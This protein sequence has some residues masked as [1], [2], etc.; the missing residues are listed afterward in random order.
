[1][2]A[3]HRHNGGMGARRQRGAVLYIAL[4]ILILLALIGIAGMQVSG[5][6]ERMSANYL[7]VNSAFQNAEANARGIERIIQTTADGGGVYAV[8]SN[9]CASGVS[10][11]LADNASAKTAHY[12]RRIDQCAA[13]SGSAMNLGGTTEQSTTSAIY[14]VTALASDVD[15]ASA[16]DA[17]STAVLQTVY[18]P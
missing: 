17:S 5:L 15:D 6:Q 13:S 11:W 8:D 3:T 9:S 16:V 7:R 4:I 14:E 18:W 10:D 1:M 2:M 12:V